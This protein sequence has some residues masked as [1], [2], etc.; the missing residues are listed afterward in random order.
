MFAGTLPSAIASCWVFALRPDT[1]LPAERHSNSHQR[2]LSLKGSATFELRESG[3]WL[4][5][6][7]TPGSWASA[8]TGSW[9]RW[10][11]GPE[12]LAVL[13]FHTVPAD[14]LMEEHASR[15]DDFDGP[16]EGRRY[17]A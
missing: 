2:S 13:S 17:Q 1:E 6:P 9:H 4:T 7:V 10:F 8:P 3:G 15:P 11:V 16:I 5:C 14:E 12:P